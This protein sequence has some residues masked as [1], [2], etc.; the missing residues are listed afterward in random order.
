MKLKKFAFILAFFWIPLGA[1][2]FSV[3]FQ[4]VQHDD[5]ESAVRNSS[6]IIEEK[7]FDFFF[8][9][10]VVVSNSPVAVCSGDDNTVFKKSLKEAQEGG[11]KY[12]IEITG[13]YDVS[14]S[15]NPEGALLENVESISWKVLDADSEKILGEGKKIP[16]RAAAVKNRRQGLS[17]F[18]LEIA[19]DIYKI[20]RR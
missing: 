19:E 8:D 1:S 2:A 15:T 12:F 18:A 5:S 16:P 10:G 13:D 7:F 4:I 6:Y 20:I 14:S 3:A 11:V 17:D 9:K